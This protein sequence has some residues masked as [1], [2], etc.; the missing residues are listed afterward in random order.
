MTGRSVAVL[1]VAAAAGLIAAC[2]SR[3]PTPVPGDESMESILRSHPGLESVLENAREHRL[4]AVLG[5]VEERPGG[6]SVLVQRGIRLEK[7]YFY[8]ASTVK[9]FAAV[10][11]L[12]RLAELRDDTGLPIGP[13][14]ALVYHPLFEGEALEGDDPSNVEG[15]TI[16][17]AHEIRKIFLVS[18][19][20][21]FNRLYEL[22]GQDGLAET[23]RRAGLD[24]ARI[25]H[26]L[27]ELRSDEEHR[28]YPRID[29]V[30]PKGTHTLPERSSDPLPPAGHPPRMELGDAYMSG[31]EK[32]E[33]PMDFRPKN[34]VPLAELQRGLCMVVRPDVDCGGPGFDLSDE[35]RALLVEA[36]RQL[37]RESENPVYD[38]E[39]YADAY[40]KFVLPGVRRVVPTAARVYDKSGQAYGTTTDNAWIVDERTGRSFFLAATLYTN[41]NGVLNDDDYAYDTVAVPFMAD[42]GEAA[43]R[44]VWGEGGS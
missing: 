10:A 37:P 32:I 41:P 29:F 23:L 34:Y 27:S 16:T 12:E 35:D 21:A 19:N 33:E 13:H 25:V 39:E 5:F 1:A 17:V 40:V 8:P 31:G 18:D 20:E 24:D 11:A 15:G 6:R 7:E 9:L 38:P 36:M 2:A 22:V 26:R 30:T 28:R 3:G 4:Q 14:T 44:W 43:T 42:L